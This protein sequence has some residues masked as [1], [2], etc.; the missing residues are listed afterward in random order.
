VN[1]LDLDRQL[2]EMIIQGKSVEAFQRFYAE[3]VVAQENDDP[4][5]VGRESW[6]RA[7]QE[8]EKSIRKFHARVLAN[9]AEGNT[10]F[11]EWEY[12]LELE[13]MGAMKM[14]QVAVRRWKDGKVVRE[15]FYHK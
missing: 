6:M 10:S 7:R 15:R 8:M 2:N 11:S 13:G 4:E 3:D 5:R 14:V 9:A 12:D 1:V